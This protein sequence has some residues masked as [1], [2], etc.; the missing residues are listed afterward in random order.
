MIRFLFFF[1]SLSPIRIEKW[2]ISVILNPSNWSKCGVKKCC[3]RFF[4]SNPLSNC[5]PG[6]FSIPFWRR[7]EVT[8]AE[9]VCARNESA[10]LQQI[11]TVGTYKGLQI[12]RMERQ[13]VSSALE[14]CL[15]R[16]PWS[17]LIQPSPMG[18]PEKG[19]EREYFFP[20]SAWR[21]TTGRFMGVSPPLMFFFPCLLSLENKKTK[22]T[23]NLKYLVTVW[24]SK[25]GVYPN[26]WR[27][28][29][30]GYCTVG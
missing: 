16:G 30:L 2:N 28:G 26:I 19:W 10:F 23:R 6:T 8:S 3:K 15:L 14:V 25:H 21:V 12:W 1:L 27:G 5:K 17:A 20:G 9:G 29:K 22:Q 18:W 4:S 24:G 7:L 13:H 11:P